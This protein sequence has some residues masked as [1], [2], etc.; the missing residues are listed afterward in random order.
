MMK[1]VLEQFRQRIQN[2]THEDVME[3]A[4]TLFVDREQVTAKY[5][6]LCEVHNGI[7]RECQKLKDTNE[8][9]KAEIDALRE[10]NKHLTNVRTLQ[11]NE[12]F[13]R[14]SEKTEDLLGRALSA[15]ADD[16]QNPID[17]DADDSAG[18]CHPEQDV[19]SMAE[20]EVR[21]LLKEILGEKEKKKKEKGKR[22]RD[23]AKLPVRETYLFDARELNEA[24]GDDWKITGWQKI[25]TVEKIRSSCYL[26]NTYVPM[27]ETMTGQVV[28]PYRPDPLIP[29]SL[30]SSSLMASILYDKYVL[31][32][33]YY[34][35]ENDP[36]RFGFRISRQ[37]MSNCEMHVCE[38]LLLPVYNHLGDLMKTV[39]PYQHCDETP[40]MVV[41]DGRRAGAKGYMWAHLSGELLA[42]YR[43]A[44]IA[45]ELTREATHLT[46]FFAG[47][48]HPV[49]LTDDAYS[50]YYTLQNS[51][52]E[53]IVICGCL[54]HCR[55]RFVDAVRVLKLP[56][57]I[58]VDELKEIPECKCVLIIAEIYRIEET[59]KH[60]SAEK[61]LEIRQKEE[62]PLFNE[63][64]NY[65]KS[66][67]TTSPD[68]SDTMKDAIKYTLNQEMILRE[69]LK[70]GN[71]P[72][73]NSSCERLIRSIA[74]LRVNSLFSTTQRGARS[75]AVIISL[76]QT[77]RLNGADPYYY[78]KYLMDEMPKHLYQDPST[79]VEEMMPWTERY[80]KYEEAERLKMVNSMIPPEGSEKPNIRKLQA[81]IKA[82]AA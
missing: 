76:V 46:N 10:Q 44:F 19:E 73:D 4:V 40:W 55:R 42:G 58:S 23:I 62:E 75:S 9:Y 80:R 32:L 6:E 31:F 1:A 61:R 51:N 20:S 33:P 50:G 38:E 47:L 28:N 36:E 63:L 66:I 65:V 8:K 74:R 18:A 82:Q 27:V 11:T 71:V 16:D 29:K 79:Y 34:R 70:D 12:L 30:V 48:D 49:H 22:E 60:L 3:T 78:L 64:I 59:I 72:I 43:I 56:S 7:V 21:Q 57:N 45:F 5:N 14:S 81:M 2:Q 17:E 39:I 54:T 77:A 69:F 15:G 68:V 67:D 24:Y 53:Y 26:Q 13:G 25:R 52:P 35:L 41:Q 37:T